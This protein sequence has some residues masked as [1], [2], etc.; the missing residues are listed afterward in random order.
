[1]TLASS[2]CM[3]TLFHCVLK[4]AVRMLYVSGMST[5]EST[6]LKYLTDSRICM[7]RQCLDLVCM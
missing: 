3:N 4:T 6:K 2:H 5:Q 1:M 7:F